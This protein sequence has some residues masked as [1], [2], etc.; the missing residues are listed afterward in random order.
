VGLFKGIK[1][2]VGVTK[3]ARE[4]QEQQQVQ[5]GYQPGMGGMVS[6]MG[7]MVGQMSEQ[8][9]DLADQSG[10]EQRLLAEGILGEAV[11]VAMGTPARGAVRFNLD[12]DLEVYVDGR[13]P[14]RVANQYIVPASAP[15][16]QGVRLPVRVDRT[17]PAKIAINWSHVAQGPPRGEVRPAGATEPSTPPEAAGGGDF[18]AKLER[19][20]AL[21]D[22]GALTDAEFEQQKARLLG[23]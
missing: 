18:V 4:L 12:I 19:L 22:S 14:Y 17:D 13:E 1:A 3:Q 15:L 5:A 9:K 8:L 6:Q 23:N 11:I 16:G 21:R 2:L 10:D 7:D 20:A